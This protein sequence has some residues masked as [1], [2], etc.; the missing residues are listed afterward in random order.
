MQRPRLL[1]P[2]VRCPGCTKRPR[3]RI[4]EDVARQHDGDPPGRLLQTYQCQFCG[5]VYD[6]TAA[7]YQQAA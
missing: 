5:R 1:C 6:V 3:V 4:T 2:A 7:A